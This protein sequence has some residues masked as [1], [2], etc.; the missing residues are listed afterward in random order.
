[1]PVETFANNWAY[2]KVELNA[3]ERLILTAVARQKKDQKEAD[4]LL[5][6]PAD[7]AAQHWFQGIITNLEGPIGYDSPPPVRTAKPQTYNQQLETRIQATQQ[8][9]QLLALPALCD[10][11]KL[12][13]YEKN[14]ILLGIAPEIHR[15][16]AKLYEYLNGSS[17]HLLTIDLSLRLLCRN[18]Q[19]WRLA[20]SRLKSDAPLIRHH[21]IDILDHNDRA[22]LQ[23][24]IRLSTDLVNYLLA[25]RTTPEDL[26][27]LLGDRPEIID[28]L[29]DATPIAPETST[30]DGLA[31]A[32]NPSF[33]PIPANPLWTERPNSLQSF[34]TVTTTEFASHLVLPDKLRTQLQHRA[35]ALKLGQIVDQDWGFGPWQGRSAP[36]PLILMV[37]ATGTGKT[38]AAAAIAQYAG[39]PLFELDLAQPISL[40]SVGRSLAAQPLTK[41]PPILLVRH[42]DRWLSRTAAVSEGAIA[43]FCQAR[44]AAGGLT[45]FAMRRSI[46]L[47][48]S[49]RHAIGQKLTFP[50]PTATDRQQIWPTVFP[51]Q[52]TLDNG[53]D[54]AAIAEH[55][56]TGGE[57][58]QVARSAAIIALAE[59]GPET[60]ELRM[61]IEHLQTAIDRWIT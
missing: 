29:L 41:Q 26:A 56:L 58:A 31:P 20:R 46:T 44:S 33:A 23:H 57:I 35:E 45:I 6:T 38:A 34:A 27:Q 48:Q 59:Q 43:Q 49:W 2:L 8:T 21:L 12:T 4:R 61:T 22:F 55:P 47:P 53:I 36:G 52:V 50:K 18:D 11:L 39:L 51:P 16:Y 24:S 32:L 9:G 17:S 60:Q 13:V 19:E 10:R 14:L 3:L 1:M 5:R 42:A 15:R 25:D 28:T 54:W 30:I 7:R 40:E 37:G